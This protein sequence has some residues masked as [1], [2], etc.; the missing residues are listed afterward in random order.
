MLL[1]SMIIL[2]F[3]APVTA[4]IAIASDRPAVRFFFTGFSLG[5]TFVGGMA[6]GYFFGE[7]L[8]YIIIMALYPDL[9][10]L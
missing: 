9:G 2:L 10:G 4:M 3:S 6:F 8:A 1:I 5:I 7:T